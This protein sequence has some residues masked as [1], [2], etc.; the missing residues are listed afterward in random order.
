MFFN[1]NNDLFPKPIQ[2]AF[3]NQVLSLPKRKETVT[4][5]Q[6]QPCD[7]EGLFWLGSGS[8]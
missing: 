1:P 8:T 2:V 6:S 4:V 7:D 5:S 3:A